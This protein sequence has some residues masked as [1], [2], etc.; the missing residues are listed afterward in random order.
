[1]IL[2][3]PARGVP[4]ALRAEHEELRDELTRLASAPGQIGEAATEVAA[5][6]K[7]HEAREEE[8]AL[9]PLSLL[10]SLAAGTLATDP[11]AIAMARQLRVELPHMLDE[12]LA[13]VAAL[14]VLLDKANELG[15]PDVSAF[16]RRLIL[17]AELEEEVLYPA[18]I[19]VGKYLE[20]RGA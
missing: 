9:P 1:M 16:A 6:F 2:K 13:I 11:E 15:R 4:R 19:L 14:Q 3:A 12:H 7:H 8:F 17:H 10:P 5:A 18:A 20:E